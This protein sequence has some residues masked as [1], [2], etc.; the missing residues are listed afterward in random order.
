MNILLVNPISSAT[1]MASRL[2]NYGIKSTAIYTI[3]KNKFTEFCMPKNNLFDEEIWLENYSSINIIQYFA[4]RVFDYVLNGHDNNVVL[5][6]ELAQHFTPHYANDPL[7]AQL[8]NNKYMMHETLRQQNMRSIKQQIVNQDDISGIKDQ[9]S[10][11]L[12]IKPLSG[13]GGN[14]A[15]KIYCANDLKAYS[16]ENHN[17]NLQDTLTDSTKDKFLIADYISGREVLVDSFSK[18]GEHY[19][20]SIQEYKRILINNAPIA[21]A[22]DL[23]HDKVL[24]QAVESYVKQVLSITGLNNGFAHTE[25][26]IQ[27]DN[28]VVLI[29]I[30]PRISGIKGFHNKL[31]EQYGLCS[32]IDLL[33]QKI[34][35]KS[36]K[37]QFSSGFLYHQVLFFYNHNGL[38]MP[39]L[40][41]KLQH[42]INSSHVHYFLEQFI[43]A[44]TKVNPNVSSL[45]DLK[46]L[47]LLSSLDQHV[48]TIATKQALALDFTGWRSSEELGLL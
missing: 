13:A 3:S 2:K 4:G 14:G 34:F 5:A 36:Q 1:Y 29:E 43:S 37:K 40:E 8:R 33:A 7:S 30:N 25:L 47:A 16:K 27:K 19:I 41:K 23:L 15:R 38:I 35:G 46:A 20:S 45:D 32:Q 28:S 42:T 31:A 11:P 24:F 9:L 6:D 12:F 39:D 18:N 44:G 48:L 22:V 17:D 21:L 10:Y 26:F